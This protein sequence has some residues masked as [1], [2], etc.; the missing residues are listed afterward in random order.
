MR[1]A[2]ACFE[3]QGVHCKM[4]TADRKAGPTKFVFDYCFIPNMAAIET[5]RVFLREVVGYI[6]YKIMGY[7]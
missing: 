4:F 3:K 2:Y 5:W 6:S 1:R 7:I